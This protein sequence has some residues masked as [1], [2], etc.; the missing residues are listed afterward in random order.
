MR[1]QAVRITAGTHIRHADVLRKNSR[2]KAD[3][4][5]GL[6]EIQLIFSISLCKQHVGKPDGK[7]LKIRLRKKPLKGVRHVFTH[8]IAVPADGWPDSHKKVLRTASKG[9]MHSLRRPR[10]H[11]LRR[12]PPA[13]V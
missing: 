10:R 4:L 7:V 12:S 6:P 13:G 9:L 1:K 11:S 8:L 5:V 3:R 2:R